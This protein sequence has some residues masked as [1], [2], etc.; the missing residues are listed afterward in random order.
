MGDISGF[1]EGKK[2]LQINFI[3]VQRIKYTSK[4]ILK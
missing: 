3:L 4:L 2:L 1:M